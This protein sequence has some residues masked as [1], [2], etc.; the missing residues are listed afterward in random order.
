MVGIRRSRKQRTDAAI[1]YALA[2]RWEE[3]AAEN[4]G[5]IQDYP[6][7]LEAANRLG[8]A[9]QEL[10]DLEGAAEAYQKTLA[11]DPTNIIAKKNL[12]RIEELQSA[13]PKARK[14][15]GGARRASKPAAGATP[16]TPPLAA[17]RPH[18]LIEESGRSA[19]FTLQEPDLEALTQVEAGDPGEVAATPR[20]VSIRSAGGVVL[21][22]LEPGAG[23]R[24]RRLME[25]GNTYAVVIRRITDTEVTVY[26]RET[27]RAAEQANEPSFLPPA[28]SARKRLAPRAYTKSIVRYQGDDGMDDE[29]DGDDSWTPRGGGSNSSDDD[30]MEESG[31]GETGADGD[32]DD[33]MDGMD[34]DDDDGGNGGGGGSMADDEDDL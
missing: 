19:E 26:I 29:G 31:F 15:T 16:G 2:R 30:E 3:A 21:G 27:Y 10:G 5:L 34:G 20:G 14:A 25:G 32:E 28:T 23:L 24:L 18:S 1:A 33:D 6:D 9:L 13:A 11:L 8:K 12:T 22:H 4:R 17:V 7:D